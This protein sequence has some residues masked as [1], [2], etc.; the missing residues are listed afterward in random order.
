MQQAAYEMVE[1]EEYA[2]SLRPGQGDNEYLKG[3][4][5]ST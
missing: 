4:D 3:R 1:Q 5:R 2:V